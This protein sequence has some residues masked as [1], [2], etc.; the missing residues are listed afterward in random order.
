MKPSRLHWSLCLGL[1]IVALWATESLLASTA[2]SDSFIPKECPP[3]VGEQTDPIDI[4]YHDTATGSC[5]HFRCKV[6]VSFAKQQENAFGYPLDPAASLKELDALLE[7]ELA[8]A[9]GEQLAQY[10]KLKVT[11]LPVDQGKPRWWNPWPQY[12]F[13]ARSTI[14]KSLRDAADGLE[15]SIRQKLP[16]LEERIYQEYYQ[17]RGFDLVRSSNNEDSLE[18]AYKVLVDQA[19]PKL[20]D[21]FNKFEREAGT[22]DT[23]E[24][25][26]LLV[27]AFQEMKIQAPPIEDEGRYRAGFWVPTQVLGLRRSPSN[28]PAIEAC[29]LPG[30]DCDSKAAAL[31]ALWQNPSRQMM[32]FVKKNPKAGKP[33]EAEKRNHPL[34]LQTAEHTYLAIEADSA[35]EANL[36]WHN[37]HYVLYE[38]LMPGGPINP[39]GQNFLREFCLTDDCDGSGL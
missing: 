19:R 12:L 9:V 17:S 25:R 22:G 28:V 2:S 11:H 29:C 13:P 31:S 35:G 15:D 38:V 32:L 7:V 34:G 20:S 3:A 5:H 21:C 30:G 27:D 6:D 36:N 23:K 24:L 10:A 18:I 39:S 33:D 16:A 8:R 14:P 1:L 26:S 4:Q 37:R